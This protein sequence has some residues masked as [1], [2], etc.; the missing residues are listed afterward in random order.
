MR[1][2]GVDR[3]GDRL[4]DLGDRKIKDE[5]PRRVE[6]SRDCGWLGAM[7]CLA[8]AIM[9]RII[10]FGTSRNGVLIALLAASSIAL[11]NEMS[12]IAKFDS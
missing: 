8:R 10:V 2:D 4:R 7:P 1:C 3:D 9:A 11:V 12:E 6:E 5:C